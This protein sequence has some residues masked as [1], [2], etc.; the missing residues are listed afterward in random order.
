[1]QKRSKQSNLY[2]C[3]IIRNEV[4]L[5]FCCLCDSM[6]KWSEWKLL[7]HVWLF[8]TLWT[9]QSM[10]FSRPEYWRG[11]LFPSP[12]DLPNPRIKPRSPTLQE[13]RSPGFFSIWAT[14]EAQEYWSGEPIPSPVD[15]PW[16]RNQ[17][18]ISCISGRFFTNWAIKEAQD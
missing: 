15:L 9:L 4:I 10:G 5:I 1:M 3:W 12:G 8:A 6:P 13:P 11:H 14:K 2:K 17:T 18:R 16:P 7:S